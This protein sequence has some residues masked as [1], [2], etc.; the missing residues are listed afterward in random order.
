MAAVH[1]GLPSTPLVD[2]STSPQPSLTLNTSSRGTPAAIPNKHL[3]TCSPGPRPHNRQLDS[4]IASPSFPR[5]ILDTTTSLLHPPDSY[6]KLSD[7]PNV[8]AISSVQLQKALDH[9]ASHPLP[10]PNLLFPWLHGLH[11]ENK[12]Q[13]AFFIARRK[14]LRK[15]PRCLRSTTIVKAGGNLSHSKLKGAIAPQELLS[16]EKPNAD[17]PQFLDIDP[18]DGFCV[19]NFQ[20]QAA[21]M[22]SVS[23]VVV[24]GDDPTSADDVIRLAERI[25]KAQRAWR[26]KDRE[27]GLDRPIFSTFVVQGEHVLRL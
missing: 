11:P 27:I 9:T 23:D 24:Y 16:A 3:P 18:K 10:D 7:Q 21:K 1:H 26:E 25:S 20:I 6:T 2:R 17:A 4:P 15:A 14:A 13:L 8:Y 19:R 5:T 22:A 12:H